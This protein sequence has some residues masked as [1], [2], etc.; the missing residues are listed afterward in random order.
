MPRSAAAVSSSSAAAAA[1]G[2][3]ADGVEEY[4]AALAQVQTR[5]KSGVNQAQIGPS[6]VADGVEEYAAALAACRFPPPP[7]HPPPFPVSSQSLERPSPAG[8][9]RHKAKA[10]WWANQGQ[11]TGVEWGGGGVAGNYPAAAAGE[12]EHTHTH[13]PSAAR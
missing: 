13:T 3:V 7:T 9:E 2:A 10:V 11:G 5:C 1:L 12:I 4:A 8:L 6:A